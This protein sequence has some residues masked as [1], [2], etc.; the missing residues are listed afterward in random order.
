M[1][2]KRHKKCAPK[3]RILSNF[4][5]KNALS[6]ALPENSRKLKSRHLLG[7]EVVE[8]AGD[9]F[10]KSVLILVINALVQRRKLIVFHCLLLHH[11]SVCLIFLINQREYK[12]AG[13]FQSFYFM[14]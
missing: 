9:S 4:L 1:R 14:I 11:A 2:V 7:E 13:N 10:T 8:L 5:P 3:F 6:E 12:V